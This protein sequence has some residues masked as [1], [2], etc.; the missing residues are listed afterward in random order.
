M[1]VVDGW[2]PGKGY[3][4][5]YFTPT[6]EASARDIYF[7]NERE[8]VIVDTYP[9]DPTREDYLGVLA[10]EYQHLIHWNQDAAETRFLN[11]AQ[12]QIAFYLNDYGHA[13]QTFQFVRT[14]DTQLDEFDNGLDDYGEVYAWMYYLWIHYAG[15]TY[16]E[17][18]AFY[19]AINESKLK[20]LESIAEVP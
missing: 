9:S 16:D 20:G 12:S 10:H 11:E 18:A 6:N 7:S 2:E 15:S 5:G 13:P 4:G 3:V 14:P 1:D 17:R 8:M 19:R